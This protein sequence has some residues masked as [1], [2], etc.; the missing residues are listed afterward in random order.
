MMLMMTMCDGKPQTLRAIPYQVSTLLVNFPSRVLDFSS[1]GEL[2][3]P[4]DFEESL[5]YL[6]YLVSIYWVRRSF[7]RFRSS[8]ARYR[9]DAFLVSFELESEFVHFL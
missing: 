9:A 6:E 3:D 1:R 2:D 4:I 7:C 8:T 5:Q